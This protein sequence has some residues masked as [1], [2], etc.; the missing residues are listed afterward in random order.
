MHY[1]IAVSLIWAF[2]FGLIKGNLAGVDPNFSAAARLLISLLV[3][4][5][6][7]RPLKISISASVR[8]VL[9][10]AIQYGMMYIAYF[11]AFTYLKA[12]EV[13]LFTIFTPL[14]VTLINDLLE[15]RFLWRN[16]LTAL[17][18]VAGTAIIVFRSLSDQSVLIG[19]LIVQI[20]N[21]CFAI[22][23]LGYRRVM[24]LVPDA[25]DREVFA[26]LFVGASVVAVVAAMMSLNG[27]LP[28][29]TAT[30]QWTLL[31]LGILASGLGFFWWNV[32]AR[33]VAAGT[34]AILNNLKV[35]LA[36]A[37]SILVFQEDAN[38]WRLAAGGALILIALFWDQR[39]GEEQ[40]SAAGSKTP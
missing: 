17:L 26:L 33:K 15:K 19:F 23:Q 24:R 25:R 1:L 5:P 10:G 22:G 9:I 30:H 32:G 6:F 29:L 13:A 14:Y 21:L 35:P 3:F 12:F 11:Y 20:S 16:L 36:V 7:F 4:L 38:L 2:S 40:S 34:L 28:D 37:V 8:L 27:K 18:T 39:A 31:Y